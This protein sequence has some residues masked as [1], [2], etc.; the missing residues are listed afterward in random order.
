[1]QYSTAQRCQG[2]ASF[3]RA[4]CLQKSAGFFLSFRIYP[5]INKCSGPLKPFEH[6]VGH[7][8]GGIPAPLPSCILPPLQR[9][10]LHWAHGRPPRDPLVIWILCWVQGAGIIDGLKSVGLEKGRGLLLL[11]E[12]SSKGTLAKG[13]GTLVEWM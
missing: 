12:M 7:F 13:G 1:M 3:C 9:F 6:V 11:A 8:S 10:L 4:T 2:L 5:G